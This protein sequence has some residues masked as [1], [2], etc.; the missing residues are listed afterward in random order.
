MGTLVVVGGQGNRKPRSAVVLP[1]TQVQVCA[2]GWDSALSSLSLRAGRHTP[3][4]WE[5]VIHTL[6][7]ATD[8]AHSGQDTEPDAVGNTLLLALTAP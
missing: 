7:L 1:T 6:T 8:H 2:V 4:R 5:C 3:G